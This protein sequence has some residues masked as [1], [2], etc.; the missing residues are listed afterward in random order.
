MKEGPAIPWSTDREAGCCPAV[1]RIFFSGM[2]GV[3]GPFA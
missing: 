2:T 1:R 3:P